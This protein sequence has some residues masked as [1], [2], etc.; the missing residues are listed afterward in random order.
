MQKAY[1]ITRINDLLKEIIT[2][3]IKKKNPLKTLLCRGE[4]REV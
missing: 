1:V 3:S 2:I 4:L